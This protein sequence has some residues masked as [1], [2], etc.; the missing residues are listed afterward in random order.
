MSNKPTRKRG[1]L[2]TPGIDK[3]HDHYK[4]IIENCDTIVR[5]DRIKEH[6]RKKSKLQILDE[7]KKLDVSGEIVNGLKHIDS[8]VIDDKNQRDHT[9]WLLS[10]G[11]S[12]MKLPNCD[13]EGFKKRPNVSLPNAFSNAGFKATS[14][15]VILDKFHTL[16]Y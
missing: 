14:S 12:S 2:P 6:F 5:G 13:T 7:A 3:N 1:R 16:V 8:F 10:N 11:F 15:K 4:C 9:R